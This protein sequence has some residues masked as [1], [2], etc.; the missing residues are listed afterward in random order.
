VAS[1]PAH[2]EAAQRFDEGVQAYGRG[3][4][5]R[6]V[7]LFE[8]AWRLAP[9]PEVLYNLAR[10]HD[11]LGH[12]ARSAR[13]Y[14][15]YVRQAGEIPPAQREEIDAAFAR[16]QR[17]V[18]WLRVRA[19]AP[20]AI[21][22]E[23]LSHLPSTVP[24]AVLPGVRTVR[25]GEQTPVA[26]RLRPGETVTLDFTVPLALVLISSEG[27]GELRTATLQSPGR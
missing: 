2:E 8:H 24:I 11:T 15:A 13:Y 21:D 12:D 16:L 6:A 26:V 23:P 20:V 10:V 25:V 22:G 18:A 14:V 7:A 27:Q 9:T 4:Y 3:E 17:R 1:R 5:A 19:Q